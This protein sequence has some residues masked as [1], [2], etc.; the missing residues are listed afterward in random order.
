MGFVYKRGE[1]TLN[2]IIPTSIC[3]GWKIGDTV[4]IE[5]VSD[6][7]LAPMVSQKAG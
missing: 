7:H 5:T 3:G 1:V 4:E 6:I 2:A